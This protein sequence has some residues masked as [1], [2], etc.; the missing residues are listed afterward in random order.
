MK[1]VFAVTLFCCLA[2]VAHSD[3]RNAP[4]TLAVVPSRS[5]AEERTIESA[6]KS[7][8]TFHVVLTNVS[9]H[10]QPVWQTWCSW[11]FWTISFHITMPD[12]KQ[13]HISRDQKEKFTKNYPATFLVS[14]GHHQVYPIQLDG[15][16]DNRPQFEHSG[17]ARITL[18]AIYEVDPTP[19]ATQNGVWLGR[20]ESPSYDFI[21]LHR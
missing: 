16:W 9:D 20:V 3:D 11:G 2:G 14:P 6:A 5:S 12:G 13:L 8:Q 1:I 15:E 7:P 4:L 10:A 19:E 21:L 17:S 18:K